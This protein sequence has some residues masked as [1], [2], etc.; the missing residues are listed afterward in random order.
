MPSSQKKNNQNPIYLFFSWFFQFGVCYLLIINEGNGDNTMG[1]P[2][3]GSYDFEYIL[4]GV[5]LFYFIY[6][7]AKD[8]WT[9]Q[10]K[11]E[12]K[13]S[14]ILILSISTFLFVYYS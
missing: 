2:F 4:G 12:R 8:K 13:H 7:I 6:K 10:Y 1:I 11:W 5:V 9:R 3:K 14:I